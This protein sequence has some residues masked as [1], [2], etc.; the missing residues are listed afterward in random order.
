MTPTFSL[1][2]AGNPSASY[3]ASVKFSNP[4]VY[5]L[6]SRFSRN[7]ASCKTELSEAERG[8]M[9]GGGTGAEEII[10]RRP[11]ATETVEKRMVSSC[12]AA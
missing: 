3:C 6:Y 7:N 8:S 11:I 4:P 1:K 9:P 12:N 5:K 2:P 10:G